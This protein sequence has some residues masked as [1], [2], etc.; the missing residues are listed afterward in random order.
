MNEKTAPSIFTARD[1]DSGLE[2]R[3]C[4]ACGDYAIL[5]QVKN[6]L[7]RLGHRKEDIVFISGIGC[8]SRF[9]YYL[10]T[11][12]IHSI[13]GR[14]P[15]LATGLKVARPELSVWVITG[16]GDALA[17]GGN[18]FLHVLRRN[19][20]INILLFNNQIYGLTKGQVSP[21][22]PP[23][24]RTPTTPAGSIDHPLSPLAVALGA[25]ATFVARTV[26]RMQTHMADTF[27]SAAQHTGT[28]LVEIYQHC[29]V[30][31]EKAFQAIFDK[32][33][34][35]DNIVLLEPGKPLVFGKNN[36]KALRLEGTRVKVVDRQAHP[37]SELWIHDPADLAKALLL[38]RF[39]DP[40]FR[41]M[42]GN[43]LPVPIGVIFQKERTPYETLIHRQLKRPF[44]PVP[45]EI[46]EKLLNKNE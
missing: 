46:I 10:D 8:S 20:D 34:R 4:P 2:V 27:L 37:D 19:P 17:I 36:E 28:A 23:E 6:I 11:Y 40:A 29:I 9:P 35:P 45:E 12:G 18:H 13:H 5:K 15:T 21:T 22:S 14:A 42:M 24:Q 33:T 30:F 31:N 26:D 44:G 1:L 39:E 3:W 38:A 32:T 43:E 25:G 7:P 41:E 16:D